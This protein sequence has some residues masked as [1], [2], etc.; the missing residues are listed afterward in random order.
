MCFFAHHISLTS[1]PF[2]RQ[3]VTARKSFFL[4]IQIPSPPPRSIQSSYSCALARS[5]LNLEL[6]FF[7]RFLLLA[8]RS[9]AFFLEIGCSLISCRLFFKSSPRQTRHCHQSNFLGTFLSNKGFMTRSQ[10]LHMPFL[11][12]FL[13]QEIWQHVLSAF[14]MVLIE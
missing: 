14:K 7:S 9:F 6:L 5:L 10:L 4:S 1:L 8:V 3:N 11:L 13:S 2:Q 12:L